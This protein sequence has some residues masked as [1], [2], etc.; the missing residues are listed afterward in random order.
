MPPAS[1]MMLL[2]PRL[3]RRGAVDLVGRLD[4]RLEQHLAVAPVVELV[5]EDELSER[6]VGASVIWLVLLRWN[7]YAAMKCGMNT[8]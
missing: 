3:V 4:E 7:V 5:L 1:T 6:I 2:Q 8:R